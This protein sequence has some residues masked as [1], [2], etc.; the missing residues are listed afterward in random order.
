MFTSNSAVAAVS[1]K[2]LAGDEKVQKAEEG[3][4]GGE[5]DWV[6]AEIERLLQEVDVHS[7]DSAAG[8][9]EEE[10]AAGQGPRVDCCDYGT[11]RLYGG[12]SA[13]SH[14]SL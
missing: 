7:E 14:L 1:S 2:Q 10:E 12:S 3:R 13:I 11:V 6:E 4:G 5:E 9:G 8:L